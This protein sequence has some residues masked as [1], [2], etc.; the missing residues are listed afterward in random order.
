MYRL[1]LAIDPP[2]NIKDRVINTYMGLNNTRWVNRD[3]LHITIH[4]LGDCTGRELQEL[5]NSINKLELN[6]FNIKIKG[7]S[8]FSRKKVPN[9]LWLGIQ[10]SENLKDLY[11]KTRL[12]IENTGIILENRKFKPHLTV[13]RLNKKAVPDDILPYLSCNESFEAEPFTVN[14]I[15]L[16]SSVLTKAGAE[17]CKEAEYEL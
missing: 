13:A 15:T 8:F 16:F 12:L 2:D 5:K 3:Q 9:T 4:F 17:H 1:F 14:K 11:A 10:M 7:A 6:S